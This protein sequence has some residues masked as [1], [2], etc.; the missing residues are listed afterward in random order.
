M[1]KEIKVFNNLSK[2]PITIQ[3]NEIVE[4]MVEFVDKQKCNSWESEDK[5]LNP[6]CS[7]FNHSMVGMR[8]GDYPPGYDGRYDR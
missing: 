2:D 1:I 4:D 5:C 6:N 8:G 7:W 3:I